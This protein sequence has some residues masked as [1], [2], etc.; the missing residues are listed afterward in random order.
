MGSVARVY[1]GAVKWEGDEGIFSA[2][3]PS[4][5]RQGVLIQSLAVVHDL[6]VKPWPHCE[7]AR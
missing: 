5:F 6:Q 7:E 3:D 2:S 1:Q 4:I